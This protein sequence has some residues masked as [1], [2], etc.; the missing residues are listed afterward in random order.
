MFAG[1]P[2][3]PLRLFVPY[4][5]P[6]RQSSEH[7][8]EMLLQLHSKSFQIPQ[9]AVVVIGHYEHIVG[10]R[11]EINNKITRRKEGGMKETRSN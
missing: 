1:T 7:H 8:V 6:S 9:S 2:T 10:L 11:R 4:S 3:N 5:A